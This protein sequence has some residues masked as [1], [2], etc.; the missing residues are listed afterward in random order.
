MDGHGNRLKRLLRFGHGVVH[1][2]MNARRRPDGVRGIMTHLFPVQPRFQGARLKARVPHR[3]GR[4]LQALQPGVV[5][6]GIVG[7]P[8]QA[9]DLNAPPVNRNDRLRFH[10]AQ[11]GFAGYQVIKP[12][13]G[14]IGRQPEGAAQ[15]AV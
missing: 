1:V 8:F 6:V 4:S 14:G 9:A 7:L 3:L 2:Q 11:Q 5:Q 12:G 13:S 15:Q 10:P